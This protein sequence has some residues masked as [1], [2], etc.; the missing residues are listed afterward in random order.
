MEFAIQ[1]RLALN[2]QRNT[3]IWVLGLK[4]WTTTPVD[5]QTTPPHQKKEQSKRNKK[6]KTKQRFVL[7]ICIMYLETS[8]NAS[9]RRCHE[10]G[11]GV[12]S[13]RWLLAFRHCAGLSP[14]RMHLP[15][16]TP[17]SDL[18]QGPDSIIGYVASPHKRQLCPPPLSNS[19]SSLPPRLSPEASLSRRLPASSFLP[20]KPP[21][22]CEPCHMMVSLSPPLFLKL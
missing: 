13:K 1:T 12:C 3:Q 5:K 11:L 8:R 15:V 6:Q 7:C 19:L 9:W 20:H 2:S 10:Q 18:L 21:W 14:G 16:L 22:T 17:Y 4:V